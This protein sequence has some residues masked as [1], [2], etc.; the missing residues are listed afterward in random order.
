LGHLIRVNSGS[1]IS[2]PVKIGNCVIISA[3]AIV[4]KDIPSFSIV[5]GVNKIHD[6]QEHHFKTFFHILHQQLILKKLPVDGVVWREKRYYR[7]EM[8][9]EVNIMFE[10]KY[11]DIDEGFFRFL[12]DKLS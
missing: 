1:I 3:G 11:P 12:K 6:L 8:L 10:S 9:T 4:T 7:S 5:R 2:G